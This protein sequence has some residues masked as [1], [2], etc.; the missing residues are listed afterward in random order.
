M[1]PF[2]L[3][4]D[5]HNHDRNEEESYQAPH[6]RGPAVFTNGCKDAP[7]DVKHDEE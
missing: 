4:D 6:T 1:P 7:D 3:D 5:A 2:D